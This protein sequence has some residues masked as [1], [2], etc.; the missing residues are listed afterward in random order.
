LSG[1]LTLRG[2]PL[3]NQLVGLVT[4]GPGGQTT[5][6]DQ[7]GYF[8]FLTVPGGNFTEYAPIS[9]HDNDASAQSVHANPDR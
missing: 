4:P 8:Q 6:T 2:A 3:T 1:Y 5:K 9:A 7:N